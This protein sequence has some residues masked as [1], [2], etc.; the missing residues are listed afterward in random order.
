MA[1]RESNQQEEPM[2]EKNKRIN[3]KI[4][5][6]FNSGD[7]EVLGQVI[8]VTAIDHTAPPGLPGGLEGVKMFMKTWREAF[9][10]GRWSVEDTIAE[11]DRVSTRAT[12]T[13]THRG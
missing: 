2:S 1:E 6:A 12:F 11:G 7:L 10:D 13:G 3:Q 4:M 9:P 8:S 5:D